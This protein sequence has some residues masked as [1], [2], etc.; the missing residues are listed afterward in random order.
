MSKK[1]SI[2]L[3]NNIFT[4]LSHPFKFAIKR[5]INVLLDYLVKL[6][7]IFLINGVKFEW[8]VDQA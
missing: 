6:K 8:S 5:F 7:I 3:S 2:K 4:V 1:R